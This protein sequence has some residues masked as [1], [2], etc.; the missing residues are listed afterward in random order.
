M[1]SLLGIHLAIL[2]GPTRPE[3]A[4]ARLMEA[5]EQLEITHSDEGRSGF[6][7]QLRADRGTAAGLLD[8]PLLA[9]DVVKPG[10]RVV[11]SI[12]LGATPAVLMDGI[13]THHQL[14]GV[15][16]QRTPL[17]TVTGEDLTVLMA[18]EERQE[19]HQTLGLWERATAI[20]KSYAHLGII[21]DVQRPKGD[22]RPAP[23]DQAPGQTDTDYDYLSDLAAASGF[24]FYLKPGPT[25]RIS[26][27]YWG[28]P[29]PGAVPQGILS[30][31]QGPD[32]NVEDFEIEW[33]AQAPATARGAILD[34]RTGAY[35]PFEV[36][37]SSEGALAKQASFLGSLTRTLNLNLPRMAEAQATA[38]A[39]AVV[40]Q[41]A[42]KAL[43]AH[44][45]LDAMRYGGV[46]EA[47]MPVDVQ[48]AGLTHD[49]R[50][51]VTE[52][53]HVIRRGAYHQSF[54]LAREGTGALSTLLGA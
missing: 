25:P 1:T 16:G 18:Q 7:L 2:I 43:Q 11:I 53:T 36:R 13:I 30:V 39:Q 6:Q 32:R 20:L 45:S 23:D 21:P 4:P 28:P 19:L 31:G 9:E 37:R 12:I 44:G 3:R 34:E 22:L 27:A 46:L 26:K 14:R 40:D 35:T 52:V 42:R 41:A 47:R 51:M 54:K 17:L 33:D 49:G 5:L 38:R 8:L 24:Q 50:W 29:D 10:S 15:G 48:G